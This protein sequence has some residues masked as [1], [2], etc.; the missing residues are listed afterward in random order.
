MNKFPVLVFLALSMVLFERA[1]SAPR[2]ASPHLSAKPHPVQGISPTCDT[3]RFPQIPA[4]AVD[5]QCGNEGNGGDEAEQNTLKNNFCPTT[6][7]AT[8]ISIA[9]FSQRQDD[10]VSNGN[11][12][13]GSS[14][15]ATDRSPLAKMGEGKLVRIKTFVFTARQEGGESVNCKNHVPDEAAFH[16]IHISVVDAANKPKSTDST[17]IK[18]RKECTGIVAEV[19]PHHRPVAWTAGNFNKIARTGALVRIT[20]Q[21]FF[22]S[23]HV[24]CRDGVPVGTN[25]KRISLWEIHPIYKFEVCASNCSGAGTWQSVGDW[26]ALH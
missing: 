21:Q 25:P 6:S 26:V 8:N 5:A 3:P 15:P 4:R 14:G 17:E 23:S 11:I 7:N 9:K 10:V 16:D 12:N 1:H 22:D 20:G 24:P 2:R 18:K 13:F 19:S